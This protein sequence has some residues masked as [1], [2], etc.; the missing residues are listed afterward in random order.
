M[1]V[2][3]ES[4][5][6]GAP[7][8]VRVLQ[9]R[10]TSITVAWESPPLDQQNGVIISY[11]VNITPQGG[12]AYTHVATGLSFLASSLLPNTDYSFA[13]AASTSAGT[14]PYSSPTLMARTTPPGNETI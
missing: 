14:G 10:L 12:S 11:T 9:Q 2:H 7:R 6:P 3:F 13:V 4:A 8:N 5:V 1:S